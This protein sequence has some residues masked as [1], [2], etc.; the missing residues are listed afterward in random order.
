MRLARKNAGFSVTEMM[1]AMSI[2]LLVTA[3]MIAV[4]S[5]SLSN[6]SRLVKM[7]KLAED[8]RTTM[9]M[10]SRDVRRSSYTANAVYCFGNPDCSN[11]GS[12]GTAG[13]VLL[14]GD[15]TISESEDCITFLLDRDQDGDATEDDAGGFRRMEIDEI[16]E[17]QMWIGDASPDCGADEDDADWVAMTDP[18]QVDITGF[19]VNDDLSYNEV[20]L[21]DGDGNPLTSQ[22]VRRI[23]MTIQGELIQDDSITRTI[24]TTIKIRNNLWF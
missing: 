2:G 1:I 17:I 21:A 12:V 16:G 15:V 19:T 13:S 14:P 3:S 23:L 18:D 7:N 11:L 4:M 22:R 8:L 9:Q 20:L 6:T 5:N 24:E 10:M